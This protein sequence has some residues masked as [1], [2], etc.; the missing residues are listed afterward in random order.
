MNKKIKIKNIT[1]HEYM[2]GLGIGCPAVYLI[3]DG[4]KVAIVGEK[5]CAEQLGIADQVGEGEQVVVVDREM[6]HKSFQK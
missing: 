1:P 3:E 6:L 4:S 5:G 2:C